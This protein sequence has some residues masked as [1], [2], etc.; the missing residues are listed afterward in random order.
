[1]FDTI[2]AVGFLAIAV[3]AFAIIKFV[4]R[5]EMKYL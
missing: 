5:M 2:I 4:E 1:M 3:V